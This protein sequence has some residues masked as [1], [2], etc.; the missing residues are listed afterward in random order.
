MIKKIFIT[1]VAGFLGSHLAERMLNLGYQVIGVDNLEGGTKDNLPEGIQFHE[2]DCFNL[3]KMTKYMKGCELVYHA[4]ATAYDGLSVFAPM[5]VSQNTFQ[6]SVSVISAAI[7]N[8]VKRFVYCSSMA[9]YGD[10][11]DYPFREDM[12]P[13]PENPYGIAKLAAEEVL[14][15][16]AKVHGMEYVILVPHNIIGAKQC[17]EDPYRNVAAIMIN[18][19]LQGKQPIIYGDG[20]QKRCFSFIDDVIHCFE[21]ALLLPKAHGEIINV[22][23]DEEFVTINTLSETICRLMN[24]KHEPIYVDDRPLE[25]KYATCSADKARK[26]LD[27]NTK[28]TLEDGLKSMIQYI[29]SKGTRPF[30]YNRPLEIIN[31]LTP[32]TWSENLI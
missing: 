13:M 6:T 9:R 24:V 26:L 21:K 12:T 27:Y 20:T 30:K 22:G 29:E 11:P 1:G 4:A 5:Y 17:Y 19:I 10:L 8:G 28:T 18:R 2:A 32:K 15:G 16:L 14:K 7:Q 23:P 31:H 25:V 3:D